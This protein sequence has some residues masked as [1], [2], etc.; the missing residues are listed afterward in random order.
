VRI[1]VVGAGLA[2]SLLATY[3][4]RRGIAVEVVERRADPRGPGAADG[5]SINLGMSA[6]AIAALREVGLLDAVHKRTVPMRGR[7]VHRPGGRST[8]QPY[9][10]G[11]DQI[12]HSILRHDLNV[13]LVG[14]AAAHDGVRFRFRTSFLSLDDAA[15][16]DAALDDAADGV[17]ADGVAAD[18]VAVTVRD[19]GTGATERIA[20]DA[21]V[22]ADGAYSAVRTQLQRGLRSQLRQEFLDWG[23]RE[24]TIAAGP[25]GEP[26]IRLDALHVWPGDAGLVVSHPNRDGS[27]TGT[28]FLPHRDFAALS[29]DGFASR[30]PELPGLLPDLAAEWERNPVGSLVTVRTAP[31]HRDGRAVL[32]GDA[33]HAVY[34]FYG[35]GMNAAFEDCSVLARCLDRHPRDTGAAFAEFQRLRKRHTDVLAELSAANFVELRDGVRS[36]LRRAHA[37]ADLALDRTLGPLWTPLYTMVSH[38]TTPYADALARA[39]RQ[40]AA[41]R[42]SGAAAALAAGAAIR[43]ARKRR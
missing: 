15:L 30:F 25:G 33:A 22:G 34:P 8:F 7:V 28:V 12:L 39:R 29:A 27:H 1:V 19:E 43:A 16:D 35:Q 3:L 21:V 32:V 36:P 4:A 10:T 37:R 9:G 23:Y 41:L 17:A 20:A 2:G 5:R 31:W 13:A 11:E 42:W 24:L 6:R 38:T 18:G 26:R 14:H 40:D